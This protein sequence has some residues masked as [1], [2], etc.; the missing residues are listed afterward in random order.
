MA[1]FKDTLCTELGICDDVHAL[2]WEYACGSL[3]KSHNLLIESFLDIRPQARKV[4][5]QFETIGG[6]MLEKGCNPTKMAEDSL[7]RVLAAMDCSK[8]TASRTKPDTEPEQQKLCKKSQELPPSLKYYINDCGQKPRWNK[9]V[10]GMAFCKLPGQD[11]RY[12]IT[13][14]EAKPGVKVP[15]HKHK[16]TE[17]ILVLSGAFCDENG[18]Y[19]QGDIIINHDQSHHEPAVPKDC[20]CACT[21]LIVADNPMQFTGALTRLLNIFKL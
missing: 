15:D 18:T 3:D 7:A 8:A 5:N 10:P 12:T 17:I 1:E 6:A 9:M 19:T 13:I 16:G 4:I 21:C 20:D 11:G 2:L 14:L